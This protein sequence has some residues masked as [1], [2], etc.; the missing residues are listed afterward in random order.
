MTAPSKKSSASK[1][2]NSED[3]RS[4]S[5]DTSSPGNISAKSDSNIRSAAEREGGSNLTI[6]FEFSLLDPLPLLNVWERMHWHKKKRVKRG[7]AW[8]IHR[9]IGKLPDRPL[10]QCEIEVDRYSSGREPDQDNLSASVKG[11]LD[12]LKKCSTRNMLGLGLIADDSPECIK[13]QTIRHVP[14]AR[15]EERTFVRIYRKGHE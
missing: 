13:R 8:Q 9:Q 6:A 2:T 11:L 4:A 12:I 7:M 3:V 14:C 5:D 10:A 15:G 1:S